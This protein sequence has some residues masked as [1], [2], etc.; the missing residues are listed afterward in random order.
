MPVVARTEKPHKSSAECTDIASYIRMVPDND[1]VSNEFTAVKSPSAMVGEPFTAGSRRSGQLRPAF[2]AHAPLQYNG[3]A[4][5][6]A[7]PRLALSAQPRVV[8]YW[9]QLSRKYPATTE[10]SL[11]A[12]RLE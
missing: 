12:L 11:R 1:I 5:T 7:D 8:L 10:R 9:S 6:S 4:K 2:W 3:P